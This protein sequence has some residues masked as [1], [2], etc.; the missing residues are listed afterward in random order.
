M[1][2]LYLT[3]VIPR[4][5]Y[6]AECFVK[7]NT[8][9]GRET[10]RTGGKGSTTIVKK[11]RQIQRKMAIAITGAMSTSAGD[12]V[13]AHAGLLP[14]QAKLNIIC[15]RATV[16]LATLPAD[17]PLH[18]PYKKSCKRLVKRYPTQLHYLANNLELRAGTLETIP[19]ARR[20]RVTEDSLSIEIAKDRQKAIEIHRKLDTDIQVYSDGSCIEGQV[21]AAAIMYRKGKKKILKYKL[22][23]ER[24]HTVYE[25][26]LIG[27]YLGAHLAKKEKD[28]RG[29]TFAADNQAALIAPTITKPGPGNH[30]VEAT[31][32]EIEG[33]RR[34]N[35]KMNITFSWCPGHEDVE[36]NE[37]ADELAKAAAA[38][39][40]THPKE[41]PIGIRNGI[42][43]NASAIKRAYKE[44]TKKRT[45]RAWK[46]SPYANRIKDIDQRLI[47]HQTDAYMKGIK[48]LQR[49]KVSILTQLRTGHAPLNKFLRK[50]GKSETETCPACNNAPETVKHFLIDCPTWEEY[51]KPLERI[52]SRKCKEVRHLQSL[53]CL[54]EVTG[55]W[56]KTKLQ[57]IFIPFMSIF[58]M[59]KL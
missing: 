5:C 38:G 48:G 43:V 17:H 13:E 59:I 11:F 23:D 18:N 42:K 46:E 10:A 15:H 30:I 37:E 51:R 8:N 28:I 25:A 35:K 20:K 34:K 32:D 44:E 16:R 21:G 57:R 22:G 26:E 31:L 27:L 3:V 33:I 9:Y 53:T 12:I 47:G 1:R 54:W 39:D 56:D 29:I 41:I 2:R 52:N 45:R 36:R 14:M 49:R 58:F 6:A 7:P 55:Q 40:T 24:E 19:T 4:L 50:I